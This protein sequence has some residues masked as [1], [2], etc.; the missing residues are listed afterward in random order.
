MMIAKNLESMNLL[1]QRRLS[2]VR[3]KLQQKYHAGMILFLFYALTSWDIK[4]AFKIIWIA[5]HPHVTLSQ[6]ISDYVLIKLR[7][8]AR[9]WLPKMVRP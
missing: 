3:R 6:M 2:I 9:H 1:S 4:E 8:I 5:A 7:D